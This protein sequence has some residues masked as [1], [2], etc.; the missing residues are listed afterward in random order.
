[1][2]GKYSADWWDKIAGINRD[3]AAGHDSSRRST[4][5][6][7]QRPPVSRLR[8]KSPKISGQDLPALKAVGCSTWTDRARTSAHLVRRGLR[9][10]LSRIA[11]AQG[12]RQ[13]SRSLATREGRDSDIL[14][15][16]PAAMGEA[17]EQRGIASW[18]LSTCGGE[19]RRIACRRHMQSA[20]GS[21]PDFSLSKPTTTSNTP[22]RRRLSN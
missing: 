5:S 4:I 22:R 3:M 7:R 14:P 16:L 8:A 19:R 1:M 17:C 21:V 2:G 20:I 9:G 11:D 6:S 15:R 13:H 18:E 10:G 12:S